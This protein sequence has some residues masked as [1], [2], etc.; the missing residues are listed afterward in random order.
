LFRLAVVLSAVAAVAAGGAVAEP[1]A[2]RPPRLKVDN[3]QAAQAWADENLVQEGW[4]QVATPAS[5]LWYVS[6]LPTDAPDYPI[7]RDWVRSE[8]TTGDAPPTGSLSALMLVEVDC[9]KR[10][11]RTLEFI[12]YDY[13]NLRGNFKVE[14]ALSPAWEEMKAG[15]VRER[16]ADAI[17]R[18]AR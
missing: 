8:D 14:G 16:S 10:R 15:S 7:V 17:C 13:N 9:D 11:T 1:G 6:A 2:P 3:A 18:G 5:Q 12:F 4:L